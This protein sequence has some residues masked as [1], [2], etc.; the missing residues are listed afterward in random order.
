[1]VVDKE[2][3]MLQGATFIASPNFDDRPEDMEVDLL[4]VHG[5]SLPPREFGGPYI[6]E[7]FTNRLDPD[8]H[9]EFKKLE[10]LKVS[11]H[12]LIRRDGTVI[13]F[14]SF[15][16]RAWHAGESEFKSRCEC[17]DF[18]IGISKFM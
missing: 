10:G 7:L 12:L 3:G 18:S 13:Q 16:K 6:E 15:N 1:M 9:P 11:S 14:V 2:T 17:N 5:I 8:A 4:V